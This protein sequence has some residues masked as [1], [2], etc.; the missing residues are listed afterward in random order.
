MLYFHVLRFQQSD[1]NMYITLLKNKTKQRNKIKKERLNALNSLHSQQITIHDIPPFVL[2]IFW[3][4]KSRHAAASVIFTAHGKTDFSV[5]KIP[6][7]LLPCLFL[8][9]ILLSVRLHNKS[10]SNNSNFLFVLVTS[11]AF[12]E[13][14]YNGIMELIEHFQ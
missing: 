10:R 8:N 6:H 11:L 2:F 9:T 1:Q 5:I 13:L 14:F 3:L 7:F 12:R 4:L